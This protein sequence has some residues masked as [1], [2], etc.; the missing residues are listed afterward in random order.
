MFLIRLMSEK[1]NAFVFWQSEGARYVRAMC[2]FLFLDISLIN[3]LI[4]PTFIFRRLVTSL[5]GYVGNLLST[6][7]SKWTFTYYLNYIIKKP[8]PL[9]WHQ[10][11]IKGSTVVLKEQN[12]KNKRLNSSWGLAKCRVWRY[13][14]FELFLY[15]FLFHNASSTCVYTITSWN[16]IFYMQCGYFRT[17]KMFSGERSTTKMGV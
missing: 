9:N 13:Y 17:L 2:L 7:G 1:T 10:N 12:M 11:E 3:M 5:A 16:V 8:T 6:L 15:E 14:V 4:S